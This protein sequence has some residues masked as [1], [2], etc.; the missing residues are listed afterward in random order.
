[1]KWYLLVLAFYALFWSILWWGIQG[2][3][4][5]LIGLLSLFLGFALVIVFNFKRK[6]VKEALLLLNLPCMLVYGIIRNLDSMTTW[7][8]VCIIIAA[9]IQVVLIYFYFKTKRQ[10]MV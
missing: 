2:A 4:G 1:M 3:I 6:L 9:S 7:R 5:Y 8:T 10:R